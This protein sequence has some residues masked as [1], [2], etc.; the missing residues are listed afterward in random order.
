VVD[1]SIDGDVR[2]IQGT[3]AIV[4]IGAVAYAGRSNT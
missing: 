4:A 3:V 1:E 2:F